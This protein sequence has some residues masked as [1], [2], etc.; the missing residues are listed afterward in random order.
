MILDARCR[1]LSVR[2][3][4]GWLGRSGEKIGGGVR[5]AA[6]MYFSLAWRK[7]VHEC[8][9]VNDSISGR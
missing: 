3:P 4:V 2:G 6:S 5:Q 1:P 9:S 8:Y 7:A